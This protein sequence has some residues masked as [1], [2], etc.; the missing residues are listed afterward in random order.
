MG[1]K[2]SEKEIKE[3]EKL[4]QQL[5]VEQVRREKRMDRILV[6][7]TDHYG[8]FQGITN[9]QDSAQ[10]ND[11]TQRLAFLQ[12]KIGDLKEQI[13]KADKLRAQQF[14]HLQEL[15]GRMEKLQ[16]I[17]D[18]YGIEIDKHEENKESYDKLSK[19]LN[20]LDKQ[21]KI[22][23]AAVETMTKRYESAI[24][25]KKKEYEGLYLKK[26]QILK[27]YNEKVRTLRAK[28]LE[29]QELIQKAKVEGAADRGL[30]EILNKWEEAN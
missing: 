2:N 25:E 6:K 27:S 20:Q 15:K 13:E 19:E 10:I 5:H 29:I 16:Q 23:L 28:G 30:L 8:G 3:Y 22:V 7:G 17:A 18:H 14:E 21:K 24:S 1:I 26:A 9:N 12:E 11:T 4:L